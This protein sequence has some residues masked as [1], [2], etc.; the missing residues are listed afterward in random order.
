MSRD[1]TSTGPSVGTMLSNWRSYRNAH[2]VF[3]VVF[4]LATIFVLDRYRVA[5]A[6][7]FSSAVASNNGNNSPAAAPPVVPH[8][9]PANTPSVPTTPKEEPHSEPAE[10]EEEEDEVE[11]PVVEETPQKDESPPKKEDTKSS[12]PASSSAPPSSADAES[13]QE[14]SMANAGNSTLGFH[15]IYYINMKNRYDREDAMAVQAYISGLD[16]EDREAV[17]ADDIDPVGMPPTHRPGLI[18]A[19]EKGCWRAHANVSTYLY[20][21]VAKIS[22]LRNA[23]N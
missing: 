8:T 6:G 18:R 15:G 4:V 21:Q 7:T 5:L 22:F 16:I 17:L 10:E 2:R 23:T 20:T 3:L 1:P 14:Q 12:T 19:G 13:R 9:P 11:A